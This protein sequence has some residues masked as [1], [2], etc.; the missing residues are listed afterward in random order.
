MIKG[1]IRPTYEKEEDTVTQGHMAGPEGRIG[2]E[3]LQRGGAGVGG[4]KWYPDRI[5]RRNQ[6]V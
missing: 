6:A 1:V 3:R 5:L 4:R 2:T